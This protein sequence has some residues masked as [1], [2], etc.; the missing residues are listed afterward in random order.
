MRF[1]IV[2]L[3]GATEMFHLPALRRLP[4]AEIVGGAD[5]ST[6]RRAV[7]TSASRTP[8]YASLDELIERGRPDVVV[9][10]TPPGLH[11]EN[12]LA[13]IGGGC[14]VFC[15]KPFVETTREA[16]EV[17]AAAA[18]ADRV[19]AINHEFRENPI[20]RALHDGVAS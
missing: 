9:V 7:W 8:A 16:D 19:V 3:G 1:G 11:R 2:G 20:Y 18:S 17:I 12:C 14:H 13:A 5:L 4:S 6:E 15:E 10:A